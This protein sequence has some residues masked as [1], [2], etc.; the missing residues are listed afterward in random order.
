MNFFSKNKPQN[1]AGKTAATR[2]LSAGKNTKPRQM[3][4]NLCRFFV[5]NRDFIARQS[6]TV[7]V[8]LVKSAQFSWHFSPLFSAILTQNPVQTS[9]KHSLK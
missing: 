9:K 6:A 4:A 1:R 5:L 7:W 8:G 3:W 2:I